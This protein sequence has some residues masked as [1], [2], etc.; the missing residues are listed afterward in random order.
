MR[1]GPCE[2]LIMQFNSCYDIGYIQSAV[3]TEEIVIT[4]EKGDIVRRQRSFHQKEDTG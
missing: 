3:R 4:Y 2:I 1:V